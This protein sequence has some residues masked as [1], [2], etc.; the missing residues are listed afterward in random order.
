MLQT[1]FATSIFCDQ[2]YL[3]ELAPDLS[4]RKYTALTHRLNQKQILESQ[5]KLMTTLRLILVKMRDF[6]ADKGKEDDPLRIKH[7]KAAYMAPVE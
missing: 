6:N 3:K 4:W 7:F 5:E 2:H 1:K